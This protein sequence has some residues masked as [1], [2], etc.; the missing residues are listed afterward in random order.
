MS[1]NRQQRSATD[2]QQ[3][4]SVK[5]NEKKENIVDQVGSKQIPLGPQ[6][7]NPLRTEVVKVY[8]YKCLITNLKPT[9]TDR[10][11]AVSIGKQLD[12]KEPTRQ[13]YLPI[14]NR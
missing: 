1:D 5:I 8:K 12:N 10:D 2:K 3:P 13:F 4:T 11:N 9:T 14:D 6:S 7:H